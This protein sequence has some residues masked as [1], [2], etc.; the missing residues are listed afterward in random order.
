[1]NLP[2][3]WSFGGTTLTD[4]VSRIHILQD[5][6]QRVIKDICDINREAKLKKTKL[7]NYKANPNNPHNSGSLH[8][9]GENHHPELDLLMFGEGPEEPSPELSTSAKLLTLTDDTSVL[10]SSLSL[11]GRRYAQSDPPLETTTDSPEEEERGEIEDELVSPEEQEM[12]GGTL[13]EEEEPPD[14]TPPTK[15][16]PDCPSDTGVDLHPNSTNLHP[17][18]KGRKAVAAA[19]KAVSDGPT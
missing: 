7:H 10:S 19:R 2:G 8:L 11:T 1:M 18:R 17:K 14:L 13:S 15:A 6:I 12:R 3:P 16:S 9:S 5:K 4:R